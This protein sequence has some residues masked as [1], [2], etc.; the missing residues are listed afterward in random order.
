MRSEIRK[1][2][3]CSSKMNAGKLHVFTTEGNEKKPPLPLTLLTLIQLFA[4]KHERIF[5]AAAYYLPGNRRW[6][7]YVEF[8]FK[9]FC[10]CAIRVGRGQIAH[11]SRERN[12]AQ[13]N[14][15]NIGHFFCIFCVSPH[16]ISRT[17]AKFCTIYPKTCNFEQ[18]KNK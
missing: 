18:R 5:Y 14:K 16:A 10:C 11:Q 9:I 6:K 8:I 3:F 15:I 12:F 1:G 2:I 17:G 13:R 4:K 7:F